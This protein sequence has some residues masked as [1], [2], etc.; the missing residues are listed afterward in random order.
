MVFVSV[1]YHHVEIQLSKESVMFP[2]HGKKHKKI[3]GMRGVNEGRNESLHTENG[4]VLLFKSEP[5]INFISVPWCTIEHNLC[6]HF[7][8]V[9]VHNTHK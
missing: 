6:T 5:I 2:A 9:M 1:L 7:L 4:S 8:S 3:N